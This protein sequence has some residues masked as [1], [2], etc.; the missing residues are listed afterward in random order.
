M[1]KRELYE[2]KFISIPQ[3]LEKIQSGDTIA[4]G[5]YGNEPRNLLRQL[6]TIRERVEDVTVWINNPSEEYPFVMDNSLKGKIDLISAF[7]GAPSED[8]RLRTGELCTPQYAYAQPD[9]HRDKEAYGV[10]GGGDASGRIRLCVY[11]HEP[12][13]GAGDDGGCGPGDL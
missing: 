8:P 5:H 2:S 9:H 13:D 6:H 7:Y 12:A 4:V 11:V 1:T 10:Y 3:A